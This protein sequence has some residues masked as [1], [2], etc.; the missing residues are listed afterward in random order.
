[1]IRR[2]A[3]AQAFAAALFDDPC[4]SQSQELR[5]LHSPRLLRTSAFAF[6]CLLSVLFPLP[7]PS[8]AQVTNAQ[9]LNS[10]A[11]PENWLQYSATYDGQR[12][13]G[14]SQINRD[15]VSQLTAQ[16]AFQTSTPG[17]FE[18]TPLVVDGTMYVT[19]P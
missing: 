16:W 5:V 18:N 13:S 1:M 8:V 10:T 3:V 17:F 6:S 14:L 11:T 7:L 9:F 4:S 2:S 15:N 19:A 12:F